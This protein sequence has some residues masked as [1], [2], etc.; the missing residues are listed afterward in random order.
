MN[1][2][3]DKL[4]QSALRAGMSYSFRRPNS[5]S[6]A[7]PP[8]Q[9]HA[10]NQILIGFTHRVVMDLQSPRE[11]ANAGQRLPWLNLARGN[12]KNDLLCQLL[13]QRNFTLF[14]DANVHA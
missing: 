10:P 7:P 4:V 8:H 9:P 12:V 6:A 14:V 1:Q 11:F 5:D 2:R 13:A 3:I